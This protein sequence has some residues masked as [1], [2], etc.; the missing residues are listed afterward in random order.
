MQ[1]NLSFYRSGMMI[2]ITNVE[3]VSMERRLQFFKLVVACKDVSMPCLLC[4]I[5]YK[6]ILSIGS[7]RDRIYTQRNMR[8]NFSSKY[9][10]A[11]YVARILSTKSYSP[12]AKQSRFLFKLQSATFFAGIYTQKSKLYA[13]NDESEG[14]ALTFNFFARSIERRS[15]APH[16]APF[17]TKIE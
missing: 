8:G 2:A 3:C 1:A 16:R 9:E 6:F 4:N 13:R 10:L 7:R 5:K 15:V 17:G 12:K 11:E 14:L